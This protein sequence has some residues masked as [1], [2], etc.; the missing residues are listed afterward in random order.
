[1]MAAE[2]EKQGFEASLKELEVIVDRLESGTLSLED[3]LA[4]FEQGIGLV[5][6]LTTTLN[7]VERRVEVLM[8]DDGGPGLRVRE[9]A[10]DDAS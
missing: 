6:E 10:E 8:R 7:E 9:I 1:M 5:R 3:S 2:T 4:A